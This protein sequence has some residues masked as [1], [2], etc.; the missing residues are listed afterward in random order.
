MQC[1]ACGAQVPEEWEAL[2]HSLN[3]SLTTDLVS[4]LPVVQGVAPK[5]TVRAHWQV[6]QT[7]DC[8]EVLIKITREL[9]S[10]DRST[11]EMWVAAPKRNSPTVDL[12]T[13]RR[14]GTVQLEALRKTFE[15]QVKNAKKKTS[16]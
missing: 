13:I 4:I 6:C 11:A 8:R 12:P 1:P 9:E 3:G 10:A 14:L 16:E 2:S 5:L 15:Q 7:L